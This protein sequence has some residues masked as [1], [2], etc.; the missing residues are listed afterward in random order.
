MRPG[1]FIAQLKL[2]VL[3]VSAYPLASEAD[4]AASS[5]GQKITTISHHLSHPLHKVVIKNVTRAE[6]IKSL[7]KGSTCRSSGEEPEMPWNALAWA[8]E[9][10]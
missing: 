6:A 2:G 4:I 1:G 9:D 7:R 10:L 5:S 3:G 8:D